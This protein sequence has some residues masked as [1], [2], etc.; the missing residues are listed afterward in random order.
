MAVCDAH[1]MDMMKF[2]RDQLTAS[3]LDYVMFGHIGDNH[4]HINLL[5]DDEQ[6]TVAHTVYGALVD[7]VLKWGGTI[8][9]EHGVGK[10]KKEYYRKMIGDS[11][12]AELKSLKKLLDPQGRL[13][14]G[15]LF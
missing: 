9:A 12:L 14:V 15:N 4:L 3:G 1:F 10:L 13:G 5:P 2:Y 8:S 11:A 6:T 7:Q